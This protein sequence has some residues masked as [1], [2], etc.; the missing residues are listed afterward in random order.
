MAE[1]AISALNV[2]GYNNGGNSVSIP[3]FGIDATEAAKSLIKDG[4][5]AGTVMQN[6]DGMAEALVKLTQNAMKEGGKPM[7][8][9]E[10][11]TV[12]ENVSKVRIAYAKYLG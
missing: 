3:V 6:A 7:D 10:G 9:V 4:K 2:A 11:L 12:D 1:G 8:H 5:M